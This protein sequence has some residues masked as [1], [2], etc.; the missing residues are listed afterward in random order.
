MN[1]VQFVV[2]WLHVL[3]AITWFGYTIAMYFL[4]IPPL[5]TLPEGQQRD[6]NVRL[7][8]RSGRVMPFIALGVLLLGIIR[9]TFLG[10][11]Q[12]F[13]ALTSAYGIT[14]LVALVVTIAITVNGARNLGPGFLALKDAPDFAAAAM[15]VRGFARIDLVLFA[16][17]FSCMILMRFGY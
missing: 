5:A 13:D 3:L 12:S 14:W 1:W 16:I 10:Q 7:G 11:V 6:I 4:V 9:G 17:A 2:Q 15:K 8:E